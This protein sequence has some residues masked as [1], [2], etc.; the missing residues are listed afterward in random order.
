MFVFDDLL[1][2]NFSHNGE[3]I[4]DFDFT[5][6]FVNKNPLCE[7]QCVNPALQLSPPVYQF[8]VLQGGYINVN[9]K[10]SWFLEVPRDQ[11]ASPQL[12]SAQLRF[13]G[14]KAIVNHPQIYHKWV[15]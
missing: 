15:A 11:F 3:E 2:V 1:K 14:S 12:S 13:R 9:S 7:W 6:L 5:I 4:G 8:T 10:L